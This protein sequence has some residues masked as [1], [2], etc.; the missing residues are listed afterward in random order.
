MDEK[1]ELVCEIID[2]CLNTLADPKRLATSNTREIAT[3][4]GIIIDKF[5][6]MDKGDDLDNLDRVLKEIK[7]N[8]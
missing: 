2:G 3:A 6:K 1:K 8:I 5:T 7:G 4:L